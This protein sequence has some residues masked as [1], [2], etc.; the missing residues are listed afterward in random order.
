MP[1]FKNMRISPKPSKTILWEW[2]K[3]DL[4]KCGGIGIDAASGTF[5][6]YPL[7]QTIRYYGVD[8]NASR[9]AYGRERY[10]N[11]IG[12]VGD[13]IEVLFPPEFANVVVSTN[14]LAYLYPED[15]RTVI[16][17][18][19][20]YLKPNGLL[21]FQMPKNK[22]RYHCNTISIKYYRNPISRLYERLFPKKKSKFFMYFSYLVSRLEYLTCKIKF[23][24]TEAYIK[25]RKG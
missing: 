17:T 10:P 2:L 16:N 12:V 8:K 20:H 23:L 9:I 5:K 14:T 7:F 6:N 15:A 25:C 21:I 24:N 19:M 3:K 18:F 4:D 11:G 1:L 22:T 13:I